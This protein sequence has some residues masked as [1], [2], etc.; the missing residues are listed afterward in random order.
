MIRRWDVI[1][2]TVNNQK[3]RHPLL[4]NLDDYQEDTVRDILKKYHRSSFSEPDK[5]DRCHLPTP[6][7]P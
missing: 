1:V 5:V 4:F 6:K 2:F 7:P 3:A